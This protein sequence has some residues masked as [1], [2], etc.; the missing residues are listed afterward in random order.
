MPSVMCG[1]VST[2]AT[3]SPEGGSIGSGVARVEE[4][5]LTITFCL[6]PGKYDGDSLQISGR[7]LLV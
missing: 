4:V 6:L 7:W 3:S 1:G 5:A 2:E